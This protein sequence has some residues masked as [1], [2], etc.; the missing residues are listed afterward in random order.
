MGAFLLPILQ[1]K[2]RQA[3]KSKRFFLPEVLL[4]EIFGNQIGKNAIF[5]VKK[6]SFLTKQQS[7]QS[8]HRFLTKIT[9]QNP[10]KNGPKRGEKFDIFEKFTLSDRGFS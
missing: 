1:P 10:P 3:C 5:P 9:P 2:L 7:L 6:V 8:L 4:G